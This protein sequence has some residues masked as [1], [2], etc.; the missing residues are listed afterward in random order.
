MRHS[1]FTVSTWVLR[2]AE[3]EQW[4]PKL[5]KGLAE[6]SGCQNNIK[7][8]SLMTAPGTNSVTKRRKSLFE[9]V[10]SNQ[11]SKMGLVQAVSE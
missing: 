6:I 11:S 4:L 9:N 7:V 2:R 1:D 3:A 5:R 8:G 10:R